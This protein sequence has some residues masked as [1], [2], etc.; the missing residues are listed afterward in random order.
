MKRKKQLKNNI[1]NLKKANISLKEERKE[2]KKQQK[3]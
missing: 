1:D 3:L 2:I